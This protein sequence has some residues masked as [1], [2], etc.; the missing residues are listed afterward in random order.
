MAGVDLSKKIEEGLNDGE[1]WK[2]RQRAFGFIRPGMQR[3]VKRYPDL[4]HQLRAVKEYSV[5]H[6]DELLEQATKSLEAKGV[7]VFVAKTEEEAKAY[8]SKVVGQNLVVKSKTNAGKEIG[9][10]NHL[11]SKIFL[12]LCIK[13]SI[14]R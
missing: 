3:M 6:M 4:T 10:T 12:H 5:N 9:I 8:I 7:Q 2:G 13:S 14:G 11:I 1:A